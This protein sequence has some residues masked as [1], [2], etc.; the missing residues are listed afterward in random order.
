MT[1]LW[2]YYV[3]TFSYIHVLMGNIFENIICG[4]IRYGPKTKRRFNG[5][6]IGQS[7]IIKARKVGKFLAS[8]HKGSIVAKMTCYYVL[9]FSYIRVLTENYF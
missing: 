6:W 9:T 1:C 5:S 3:F 8:N 7:V 4:S 2:A